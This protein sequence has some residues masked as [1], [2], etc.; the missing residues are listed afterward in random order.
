MWDLVPDQGSNPNPLHWEL[1]ILATGPQRSS[2]NTYFKC[3]PQMLPGLPDLGLQM[4]SSGAKQ[5]SRPH[6][7][8]VVRARN[9]SP[10]KRSKGNSM[11][12]TPCAPPPRLDGVGRLEG[13]E[14]AGQRPAGGK[15]S[16]P[17]PPQLCL[18]N[19]I[20]FKVRRYHLCMCRQ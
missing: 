20:K 12:G 13:G 9:H 6:L 18:V 4:W 19:E 17:P 16:S 7:G 8:Q 10:G 3:T 15:D 11:I 2:Y 5:G 1:R 14:E